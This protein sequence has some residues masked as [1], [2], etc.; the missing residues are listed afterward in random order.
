MG[1]V[2]ALGLF[3]LLIV[4]PKVDAQRSW[5]MTVGGKI[6]VSEPGKTPP[7]VAFAIMHPTPNYPYA[8]RSSRHEGS[9][10][11]RLI[12]DPK[13]GTVARVLV[14]KSTGSKSLDDCA[15]RAYL[16]WRWKPGTWKEVIFPVTWVMASR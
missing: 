3:L 9:G 12:I 13:T 15:I 7:W 5:A 16:Q 11:F 8:E 10:V 1:L 6:V 2:T 4:S 14:E